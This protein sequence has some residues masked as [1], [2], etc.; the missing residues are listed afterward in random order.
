MCKIEKCFPNNERILIYMKNDIKYENV[1]SIVTQD[2]IW[3]LSLDIINLG[4]R[5]KIVA[6]YHSSPN[7][8]AR[9]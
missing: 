2:Y 3:L 6:L 1:N 7:Q 5:Y 9:V 8:D 4:A